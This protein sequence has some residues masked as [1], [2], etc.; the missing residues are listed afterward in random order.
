MRVQLLARWNAALWTLLPPLV[1]LVGLV[2]TVGSRFFPLRRAGLWL[3]GTAGSLFRRG[4]KKGDGLSP[5][6]AL[7]ASLAVTVL[8]TA[9]AVSSLAVAVLIAAL[10]ASLT[11]AVLIAALTASLAVAPGI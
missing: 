11:V 10:A 2:Y 5:R 6:Q 7:A 9:L 4:E 3:R 8:V 1:L